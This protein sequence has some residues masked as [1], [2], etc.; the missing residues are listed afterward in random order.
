MFFRE[1][2]GNQSK[3]TQTWEEHAQKLHIDGDL[4]LCKVT[5]SAMPPC[6]PFSLTLCDHSHGPT[7]LSGVSQTLAI[8]IQA[9]MWL[10][11]K[12][13]KK[14]EKNY[15]AAGVCFQ[16]AYSPLCKLYAQPASNICFSSTYYPY[17][18]CV[19]LLSISPHPIN[20]PPCKIKLSFIPFTRRGYGILEPIDCLGLHFSLKLVARF[21]I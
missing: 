9:G 10:K 18:I 7:D 3:H 20:A 13:K 11:L 1:V 6:H 19:H 21:V 15:N 12:K 5:L 16:N 17:S 4:K 2:R 14:K 8:F